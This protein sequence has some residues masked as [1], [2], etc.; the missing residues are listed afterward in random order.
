M[1]DE[2][3]STA[4]D[5]ILHAAIALQP[6]IRAAR[7]EIEQGRR[8][9]L[10]IVDKMKQA[11][12]FGMAMPHEWGGSELDPISQLRV[13]EALAAADAS[14]GW[15]AMIN[16]MGAYSTSFLDQKVARAM[17]PDLNMPTAGSIT[18]MGRAMR[19]AGGYQVSG[20]WQF[21]SGCQ[22]SAWIQAGCI[23]HDERGPCLRPNGTPETRQCLF[24]T[25]DAEIIDTWH[26]TGLRG[27]GSHDFAVK[28]YFVPEERTFS[29]QNPTFYRTGGLYTFPFNIVFPFGGPAL[30]VARAAV[31][32]LIDAGTKPARASAVNGIARP[33]HQ[34][35][36]EE[37]VQ[38]A[39]GKA[40]I[41]LCAA[42][43]CLFETIGSVYEA[44]CARQPIS[45]RL[46][47]Q[48]NAVHPYVYETCT[49]IVQLMYKTRGGS[50]VY[51]GGVLDRCLRDVM[52]INQHVL[53]S[54][55]FYSM[56]GR[57]LLGLP[58]EEFLF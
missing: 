55:K 33:A 39:I 30:G 36:D 49:E 29:F 45:L 54:L 34:L 19:V 22:H 21:A 18:L 15:C 52:A 27:S 3:N 28:D 42:R 17:Y 31:D 37:Y 16:C 11:G 12:I 1:P 14:V 4:A 58:A 50:A 56:S 2:T 51:A 7:D 9:P 24:P 10:H 5:G 23:V 25:T 47:A 32:A 8:L 35:R 40:E 43:G 26:S 44:L 20:R 48:F 6:L 38:A 13:V 46:G 41:M 53:N 57:I